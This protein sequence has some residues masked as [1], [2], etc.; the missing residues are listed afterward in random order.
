[1]NKFKCCLLSLLVSAMVFALAGCGSTDVEETIISTV[2]AN[3]I[4]VNVTNANVK[5]TL[6]KLA[7]EEIDVIKIIDEKNGHI[8]SVQMSEP[9]VTFIWPFAEAGKEYTLT[10]QINAKDN[11]QEETVTF[12]VENEMESL[13]NISEDYVNS[14]I[15]LIAKSNQRL[16]KI[17]TPY[18]TISTV[19]EKAKIENPK[20]IISLYSG[21]HYKSTAKD[22]VLVGSLTGDFK[23]KSILDPYKN[24]FDV[25]ANA[26]AMGLTPALVNEKLS[27]K[28]TY[29]AVA[30][31][32][33]SLPGSPA[34]VVHTANGFYSNDTIYT[35]I[36]E[37]DLPETKTASDTLGGEK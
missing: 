19:F 33:F 25:I 23:N 20:L 3:H 11:Y 2:E 30:Q 16:I 31:V 34:G 22:S 13:I 10:A 26:S 27:A 36:D 4:S 15:S 37:K 32:Q 9:Q 28:Q 14:V 18:S 21:K 1:M 6:S 17:D 35:P 7:G 8:T 12:K 5:I 29:F 24:G